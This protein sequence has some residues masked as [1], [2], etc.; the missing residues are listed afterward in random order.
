MTGAVDDFE[1]DVEP[2]FLRHAFEFMR[3][4]DRHLGVLIAMQQE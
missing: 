3:L 4:V 1:M 2:V